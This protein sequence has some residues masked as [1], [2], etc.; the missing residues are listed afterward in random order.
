LF[1]NLFETDCYSPR[2]AEIPQ[3]RIT[4]RKAQRGKTN[5]EI[6]EAEIRREKNISLFPGYTI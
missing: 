1:I 5:V 3:E 4:G 6:A 2:F